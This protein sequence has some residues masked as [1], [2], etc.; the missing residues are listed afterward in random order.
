MPTHA[1]VQLAIETRFNTLWADESVAVRYE[2]DPRKRPTGPF[3]RLSIRSAASKEVGFAESKSLY[4]RPGWI[5]AQCFVQAKQGTQAARVIADAVIA[6]FEGQQFSD[7]TFRESE[8]VEVGDGGNGFWQINAKVF[9]DFDL[10]VVK[11]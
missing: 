6:I 3:I 5:V 7:V 10:E 11:T 2:N 1:E 8:I 4:R 9:F